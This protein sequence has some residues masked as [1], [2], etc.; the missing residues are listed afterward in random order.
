MIDLADLRPGDVL[1][2]KG[3]GFFSWLIRTKTSSDISHVEIYDGEG[4][5]LAARDGVGVGRFPLRTQDLFMV[6][7]PIRRVN[8]EKLREYHAAVEGEKYDWLGLLSFVLIRRQKS[9][10]KNGAQFCS[11]YLT[12]ALRWAGFAVFSDVPAAAV[13]PGDFQKSDLFRTRGAGEVIV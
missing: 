13:E 10:S 7:R 5:S 1:L 9:A 6:R 4:M 3:T 11:E 12:H 2:Y 8:M